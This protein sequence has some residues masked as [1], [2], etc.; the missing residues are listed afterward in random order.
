M[1]FILFN[2][3]SSSQNTS[4]RKTPEAKNSF[5]T[6]NLKKFEI[7]LESLRDK[8]HIP[9]FSVGIVHK[10]ELKWNKGFGVTDLKTKEVPDENTV[11]HITPSPKPLVLW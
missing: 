9:G 6:R 8:H 3:C 2:G 5:N 4:I 10:G 7:D 1:S 11:Y